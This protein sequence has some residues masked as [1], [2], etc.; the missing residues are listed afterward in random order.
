MKQVERLAI[1]QALEAVGHDRRK[2]AKVLQIGLST[3]YR[4]EK[5]YGL[6]P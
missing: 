1:E 3:L 2:A 6:R 5:E 4:K